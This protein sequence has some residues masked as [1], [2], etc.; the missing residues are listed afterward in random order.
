MHTPHVTPHLFVP[1]LLRVADDD[2]GALGRLD[3]GRSA[4]GVH[5]N[6]KARD[7]AQERQDCI[8]DVTAG[9]GDGNAVIVVVDDLDLEP[10]S[11]FGVKLA[12]T[13]GNRNLSIF[14]S[15]WN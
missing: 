5:G 10:G 14:V 4:T 9:A 11:G 7:V 13:S 1:H 3:R 8:H 15:L 6:P 12:C 2:E